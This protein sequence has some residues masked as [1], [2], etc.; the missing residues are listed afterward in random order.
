MQLDNLWNYQDINIELSKLGELED[1]ISKEAVDS[2]IIYRSGAVEFEYYKENSFRKTKHHIYSIT[3]S[4]V[5]LLIGIAMDKGKIS[6][7]HEPIST[8][9]PFLQYDKNGKSE[10]T[11]HHLLTM[12]SGI[13]WPGN[14]EML[15]SDDWVKYIINRPLRNKPG[16]SIHYNCGNSHLLG[17]IL[18][19]ATGSSLD[20][21]AEKYLFNPLNITDYQW[22]TDP[23][24][25]PI[26]GFGI[27]LTSYDLLKLGELCLNEGSYNERQVVSKE[28]VEKSTAPFISTKIGNQKYAC[29]WWVSEPFSNNHPSFYYAAGSGGQYIFIVPDYE[30]I[31]VYTSNFSKKDGVKPYHWFVKYIL[32]AIKKV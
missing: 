6:N 3:K 30:L 11:I 32:N 27:S 8:F 10:I 4:I 20:Q 18:K 23:K 5:S 9:L 2:C 25:N 13:D 17:I 31:T 15:K 19:E 22:K 24:G 16:G 7:I 26:G 28:W 14:E 21:F 1:K 29:H 12:T